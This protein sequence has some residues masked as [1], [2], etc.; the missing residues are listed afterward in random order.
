MP[1]GTKSLYEEPNS[2]QRA[3]S[4]TC[5]VRDRTPI[6]CGCPRL[7]PSR[8]PTAS[9][10]ASPA[11]ATCANKRSSRSAVPSTRGQAARDTA[12]SACTNAS[13]R[14]RRSVFWG[15]AD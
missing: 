12:S 15:G 1:Y 10:A 11:A 7:A 8:R 4:G 13:C 2:S 14:S 6:L 3:A 9:G 5:A